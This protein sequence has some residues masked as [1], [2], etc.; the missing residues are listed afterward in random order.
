MFVEHFFG[1]QIN[2]H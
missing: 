1:A 2:R